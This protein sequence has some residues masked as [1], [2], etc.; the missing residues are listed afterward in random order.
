MRKEAQ[1]SMQ[2]IAGF[3]LNINNVTEAT[4]ETDPSEEVISVTDTAPEISVKRK[5]G[6]PPKEGGAMTVAERARRYR[7]KH[8]P[9]WRDRRVDLWASTVERAEKL[10]AEQGRPVAS[11]IDRALHE[12][13][14]IVYNLE[15]E[16][17]QRAAAKAGE[18][19]DLI[20]SSALGKISARE[21]DEIAEVWIR[22]KAKKAKEAQSEADVDA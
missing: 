22:H 7:Q 13:A 12:G 20:I 18:S 8:R 5:R 16:Q 11:V 17:V 6:R 19:I 4:T 10:A 2:E 3:L 9:A 21:W 14:V 1:M 15:F